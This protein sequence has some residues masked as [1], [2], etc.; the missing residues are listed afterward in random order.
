[1]ISNFESYE[2]KLAIS[3]ISYENLS[4]IDI[5]AYAITEGSYSVAYNE[6]FAI[7]SP[8]TS[9]MRWYQGVSVNVKKGNSVV[10]SN[11]A[12]GDIL[13]TVGD[14]ALSAGDYEIVYSFTDLAGASKTITYSLTVKQNVLSAKLVMPALFANEEGFELPDAEITSVVYGDS[15]VQN[16]ATVTRYYRVVGRKNWTKLNA[17]ERAMFEKHK[18]YEIKYVVEYDGNYT[19]AT[20]QKFIHA[21][22]YTLDFEPEEA[23]GNDMFAARYKVG[24]ELPDGTIA[25]EETYVM[26]KSRFLFDGGYYDHYPKNPNNRWETSTDWSK[27][28]LTSLTTYSPGQ[29]GWSGI[30]IRP[31]IANDK[32]INA[33]QFWM[34]ADKGVKGFQMEVG[35]GA[36]D[37]KP[38]NDDAWRVCEPF[39]LLAGEHFYTVY[40]K[41]PIDAFTTIGSIDM[42]MSPGNRL[43]IDDLSFVHIDR[44]EVEDINTYE[45]QID[46][47]EGYEIVKPVIT[48]EVMSAEQLAKVSYVLTYTLNGKEKGEIYPNADGK[49]VLQLGEEY[50]EV[51][52][53]WTVSTNNYWSTEGGS[54]T[55]Y[56]T[57]PEILINSVRLNFEHAEVVMQDSETTLSAPTTQTGQLLSTKIE[58]KPYGTEEWLDFDGANKLPTDRVGWYELRYT[59]E[60]KISETLTVTGFALS[61]IYVRDT[62]ILVDFE[63]EQDP[64]NGGCDY[65]TNRGGG[66]KISHQFVNDPTS[67]DKN[68]VMQFLHNYGGLQGVWYKEALVFDTPYNLVYLRV[69]AG[70][71]LASYHMEIFTGNAT[72]ALTWTT[73]EVPLEMGWNDVYLVAEDFTVFR[74]II[75][76]LHGTLPTIMIDDVTLLRLENVEDMPT[77]GVYGVETTIPTVTLKG[78]PATVSYRRKGS[79]AWIALESTSFTPDNIGVY[80]FRFAFEGIT[81]VVKE[82]N[83]TIEAQGIDKLVTTA[84]AGASVS[85][86]TVT[87][88]GLTATAFYRELGASAWTAVSNGSFVPA[89]KGTYEVRFYFETIDVEVVKSIIVTPDNEYLIADFETVFDE[90]DANYTNI[91]H[92]NTGTNKIRPESDSNR[93]EYYKFEQVGTSQSLFIRSTGGWEGPTWR[94]GVELGFETDTFKLK[95]RGSTF[96][97]KNA[98][99]EIWIF[100]GNLATNTS[101]R[102][103]LAMTFDWNNVVSLGDD[104]YEY[105]FTVSK[106]ISKLHGFS[107]KATGFY[108]DDIRAIDTS[109]Q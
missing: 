80:E 29:R 15:T 23:V 51:V 109:K 107:F 104:W 44:F 101:G 79:D 72:N 49:Y 25:T 102:E 36:K 69:Y 20:M 83:V 9:S 89:K 77:K 105:T 78:Q 57:S 16:G 42:I 41:E 14:N 82:M 48:T 93:V 95:A 45:D 64:F 47:T 58:Y 59:A 60:V 38:Y 34:K 33:I 24:D 85:V 66:S 71:S 62:A 87:A 91:N 54:I 76:K 100:T 90:D 50:G 53:N 56:F 10:K 65:M 94:E 92:V 27:S 19:E 97:N 31:V 22:A 6:T 17:N 11:L 63:G 73:W 12:I 5:N 98:V 99:G 96:T 13:Q 28:G 40:L 4:S 7:P 67:T 1:M 75:G 39:D 86:P 43:Y 84:K 52:F 55:K 108:I 3:S 2:V 35:P 106:K 88:A 74:S 81:E 18:N 61:E 70:T 21:D 30:L 8:F 46:H 68:T 103:L 26:A 37:G 32:G